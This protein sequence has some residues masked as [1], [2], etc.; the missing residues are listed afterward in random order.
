MIGILHGI[1]GFAAFIVYWGLGLMEFIIIAYAILSWLIS[2]N[3]VNVRNRGV[4]Q[5]SRILENFAQPILRPVQRILPSFGGLD[6]SPI[7]VLV[8]IQGVRI[9]LLPPFFLW[10][11][12]LVGGGPVVA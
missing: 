5:V 8:L 4:F 12:A 6:F 11:H 10:L 7:V 9:Y 1:I 3:V 2:F